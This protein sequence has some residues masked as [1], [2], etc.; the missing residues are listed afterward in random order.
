MKKRFLSILLI[1]CMVLTLFPAAAI[2]DETPERIDATSTGYE[3]GNMPKVTVTTVT[4]EFEYGTLVDERQSTET[5]EKGTSI[6]L[7]DLENC[8]ERQLRGWKIKNSDDTKIYSAGEY[9]GVSKSM[10]FVAVYEE[11]ITLTVPFTTTVKQGGNVAPGETTFELAVV[12][13]NAD[14]EEFAEDYV[15]AYEEDYSAV[16]ISGSVTT[17]GV[18]DYKSNMTFTGPSQQIRKMLGRGVFVQQ[19]DGKKDGWTYDQTVFFLLLKDSVVAYAATDDAVTDDIV[20][21]YTVL[22]FPA[23]CE[24]TDDGIYYYMDWKAIEDGAGPL[25]KMHFTNIYTK[26]IT[27]S[28]GDGSGESG[29]SGGTSGGTNTPPGSGQSEGTEP[30]KLTKPNEPNG[31][32]EL[33]EPTEGTEPAETAEPAELTGPAEGESGSEA[34]ASPQTGD[35]SSLMVWFA[36][37][38]LSAAGVMAT[39]AYG[40][41]RNSTRVR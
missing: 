11:Y 10:T 14:K 34:V 38:A 25:E 41:R 13:N 8:G 28:D 31:Q 7:P 18:G 17:N 6:A 23:I 37:L 5:V 39:G 4:Y 21:D 26:T 30:P 40:R 9:Y 20:T 32:P 2:A 35:D 27:E 19:V 1:F 33:T 24:E 36:L 22:I 12:D 3:L 29:G 15:E 16:T